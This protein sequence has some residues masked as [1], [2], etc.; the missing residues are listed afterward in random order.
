MALM[1]ATP[2]SCILNSGYTDVLSVMHTVSALRVS[3]PSI[4]YTI[5]HL[6]AHN[7]GHAIYLSVLSKS[8]LPSETLP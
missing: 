5:S 4:S 3:K 6:A 1:P 7:L 2:L 8:S